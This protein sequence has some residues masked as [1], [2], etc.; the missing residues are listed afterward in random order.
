[1]KIIKILLTTI[2]I[3]GYILNICICS[4]S[5]SSLKMNTHFSLK[6][7]TNIKELPTAKV[8]NGTYAP[9]NLT[10]DDLP[11]VP[12][13]YQGWVKYFTFS[14]SNIDKVHKPKFF[15]K[16][17]AFLEQEKDVSNK[18]NKDKEE[19]DEVS[20]HLFLIIIIILIIVWKF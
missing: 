8:E 1:M 5:L 20:Y 16:N 2:L 4:G 19:D 17:E 15:F 11:D 14:K 13:Y 7:N 3:S 9:K 6:K 18:K 10:A 12:I